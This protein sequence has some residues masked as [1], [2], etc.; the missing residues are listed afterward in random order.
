LQYAPLP[1]EVV[2]LVQARLPTLKA[3]GKTLASN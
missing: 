3:G 2:Q 1:P